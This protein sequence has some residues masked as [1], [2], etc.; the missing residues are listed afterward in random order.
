MSCYD[1]NSLKN[2]DQSFNRD[3]S[4]KKE[5]KKPSR[6]SKTRQ[7]ELNADLAMKTYFNTD[8]NHNVE[9]RSQIFTRKHIE[10]EPFSFKN[11]ANRENRQQDPRH[12]QLKSSRHNS[13]TNL[14]SNPRN[15]SRSTII[16]PKYLQF[17]NE[18]RGSQNQIRMLSNKQSTLSS[19]QQA[20]DKLEYTHP[21]LPSE[22]PPRYQDFLNHACKGP[23]SPNFN[24]YLE[25]YQKHWKDTKRLKSINSDE[26]LDYSRSKRDN[27]MGK[28]ESTDL[29][30]TIKYKIRSISSPRK[31]SGHFER[32]FNDML[33]YN[34]HLVEDFVQRSIKSSLC[35]LEADTS[36]LRNNHQFLSN[37]P[38]SFLVNE[39]LQ[40]QTDLYNS[41][42]KLDQTK[43]Y[44]KQV[45][46][47]LQAE[48]SLRDQS[49]VSSRPKTDHSERV[50]SLNHQLGE[51]R[52]QVGALT[53]ALKEK[54]IQLSKE[55]ARNSEKVRENTNIEMMFKLE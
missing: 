19:V 54:D 8:L 41:E 48:L 5:K 32:K 14:Q 23:F 34:K 53:V 33:C 30:S 43:A 26:R 4:Q 20:R 37:K 52:D 17:G 27:L 47:Q 31:S 7:P 44:F 29:K 45:I 6:C 10:T 55:L 15:L 46:K 50:T 40:L 35:L 49:A 25:Q 12:Y 42:K 3:T 16:D 38:K 21:S 36:C 18:T 28:N 2:P 24:N 1:K 39:L 22:Q 51:L 9:S 11:T 13:S